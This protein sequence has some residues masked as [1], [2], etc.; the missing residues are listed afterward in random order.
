MAQAIPGLLNVVILHY[1]ALNVQQNETFVARKARDSIDKNQG[2]IEEVEN[3]AKCHFKKLCSDRKKVNC[4]TCQT[5]KIGGGSKFQIC[6]R[7]TNSV[8]SLLRATN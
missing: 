8:R 7:A 1:G 3:R 5:S 6:A 2:V 4:K